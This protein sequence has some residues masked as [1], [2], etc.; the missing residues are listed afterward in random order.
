MTHAETVHRAFQHAFMRVSEALRIKQNGPFDHFTISMSRGP[1][2]LG[3]IGGLAWS[4]GYNA[5]RRYNKIDNDGV[6]PE[7]TETREHV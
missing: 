7:M 2:S 3:L 6:Y 4:L 5:G 1:V